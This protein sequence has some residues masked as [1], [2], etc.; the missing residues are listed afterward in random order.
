MQ[1]RRV[2]AIGYRVAMPALLVSVGVADAGGFGIAG[3]DGFVT[4]FNTGVTGLGATV[5]SVG[6]IGYVGSLMDNPF[7]TILSGSVNFI[8]KA[9]ILGGGIPLLTTLGLTA[10]GTL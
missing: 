5:G 10:G 3:L 1:W 6:L 2:F 4:R 8:T 9:G 7:S